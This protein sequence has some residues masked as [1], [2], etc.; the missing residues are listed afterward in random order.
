MV[1]RILVAATIALAG[2]V[3]SDFAFSGVGRAQSAASPLPAAPIAESVPTF[4]PW[5][6]DPWL[7]EAGPVLPDPPAENPYD[8]VIE[9]WRAAPPTPQA[10]T[11]ALRRLRLEYGLGDLR[12]PAQIVMATVESEYAEVG[13]ELA[14]E[15]A[16]GMPALQWAHVQDLWRGHEAGAAVKAFGAMFWEMGQELESRLWLIGNGMLLMWIVGLASAASFVALLGLKAIPHAA[17]D[18]GDVLSSGMP[19][20]ARFALL[21]CVLLLPLWLGEGLAG[22]TLGLF[23]VAFLYG[24]PRERSV[25]VMA[26]IVLVVALHPLAQWASIAATVVDLDPVSR[27]ALAVTKGTASRADVD[28][29]EAAFGDD[30]IAAHAIAYRARRFAMDVQAEKRLDALAQRFPTDPV[31]LANRGNIDMRAGRTEAAIGHYER[32]AAQVDSPILLFDLSQAYA[33][34]LRMD[35]SEATLVR[36]QRI[37]DRE[38]A[39]LSSLSDPRL[40]ADLSF[41]VATLGDRLRTLGLT[42]SSPTFI[43]QVLAPGRLGEGVGAASIGFAIAALLGVFLG[44]RFD[45]SGLCAR[46]GHRICTRCESTVRSDDLCDGCHH[47]FKNSDATDPKLR[48]ARL[49]VLSRRESVVNALVDL[50]SIAV[51]GVAGLSMRRPDLALFGIALFVWL[52]TWYRWPAGVLVDPLWLGALGPMCFA[53]FGSIALLAYAAIVVRSLVARRNR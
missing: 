5:L 7:T 27:S 12:A 24:Q 22:V 26:A 51:P 9:A 42:G 19:A 34:V 37:G 13:T 30:V 25:L 10:R 36:A 8:R 29:L 35:E 3:F 53:V 46:C 6:A 40:V 16:P 32:A 44:A 41:P 4:D 17:H 21:A 38:V 52:M 11:V 15:L 23:G 20:F 33:S 47:L 18:L 1:H 49:Q 48:K 31:V 45:R 43:T 50:G 28:R 14:R 2:L 39:V